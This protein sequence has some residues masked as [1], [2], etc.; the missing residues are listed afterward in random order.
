MVEPLCCTW[1][2]SIFGSRSL[3]VWL[4]NEPTRIFEQHPGSI[5]IGNMC[6][7]QHPAE[8]F[9]ETRKQELFHPT[10]AGSASGQSGYLIAIMLRSDVFKWSRARQLIGKPTP[11][12]L[13]DLVNKTVAEHV[14]TE[15]FL[16]PDFATVVGKYD[17]EEQTSQRLI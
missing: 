3:H 10:G 17:E 5:Y 13:F 9:E 11:V 16:M 6:A 2:F 14:A 12:D 1:A 4:N 7:A 15:A 8:H